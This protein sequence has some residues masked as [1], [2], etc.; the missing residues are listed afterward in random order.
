LFRQILITQAGQAIGAR[1][2]ALGTA[3]CSSI[4]GGL[5]AALSTGVGTARAICWSRLGPASIRTTDIATIVAGAGW[6]TAIVNATTK[7]IAWVIAVRAIGGTRLCASGIPITDVAALAAAAI[8]G[9]PV[10]LPAGPA[11]G[12]IV[13]AA[14]ISRSSAAV[15]A[16]IVTATIVATAVVI[17]AA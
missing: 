11:A 8:A 13:I 5:L 3:G 17:G 12:V 15:I 16:T 10:T 6:G 7:L 1:I 2:N 14:A 9:V 4:A